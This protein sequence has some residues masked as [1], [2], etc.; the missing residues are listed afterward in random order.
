MFSLE[1]RVA[2]A[3]AGHR[4]RPG[5]PVGDGEVEVVAHLGPLVPRDRA[6][7]LGRQTT[8]SSGHGGVHGLGGPALGKVQQQGVA[9]RALDQGADGR[10]VSRPHDEVALPMTRHRPVSD[11]GRALRDH[12]LVGE[13][14]PALGTGAS[15]GPTLGPPAAQAFDQLTARATSALDEE[16]LVDRLVA[17]PHHRIVGMLETQPVGDLLGRPQLGEP[18][19]DE[20]AQGR[21]VELGRL[22]PRAPAHR[23]GRGPARSG[24]D[25]ARRWPPPRA[26]WSRRCVRPRHDG[27]EALAGQQAQCDL[28]TLLEAEA[29]RTR[30]PDS[31][32]VSRATGSHAM[33][34]TGRHT[35]HCVPTAAIA[36]TNLF[37]GQPPAF[38]ACAPSGPARDPASSV[39]CATPCLDR[40]HVR[41]RGFCADP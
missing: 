22:G 20:L 6:S 1:G 3:S 4:S 29:T 30:M 39:P 25:G 12:H 15:P 16:R 37:E 26:R 33:S 14:S 17:H 31:H 13:I 19:G 2:K 23:P 18:L 8:D 10:T 27:A 28:L 35:P 9:A 5:L 41:S 24:S 34:R 40:H 32:L 7:E 36:S 21:M 11:L 38:A